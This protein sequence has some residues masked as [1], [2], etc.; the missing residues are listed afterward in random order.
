MLHDCAGGKGL[1]VV[2]NEG[3][4]CINMNVTRWRRHGSGEGVV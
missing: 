4:Q 2:V 3:Q 1:T